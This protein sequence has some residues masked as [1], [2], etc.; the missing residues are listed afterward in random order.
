MSFSM[1]KVASIALTSSRV[2]LATKVS[3]NLN[4]LTPSVATVTSMLPTL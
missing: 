2:L 4:R 1:N 3:G